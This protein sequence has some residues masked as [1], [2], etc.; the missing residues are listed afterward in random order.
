MNIAIL[1]FSIIGAVTGTA[2]LLIM[3]KTA[4]ELQNAKATIDTE[5]T[6]VK[7]KVNRNAAVVKAALSQLEL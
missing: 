6:E 7:R 4:K 3:A 2:S 1:S 5:V